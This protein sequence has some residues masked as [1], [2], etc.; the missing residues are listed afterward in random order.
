MNEKQASNLPS[1]I[2]RPT[3]LHVDPWHPAS[4][5]TPRLFFIDILAA[6]WRRRVRAL[7]AGALGASL[8][9]L[10]AQSLPVRYTSTS[11][12][13]I[14]PRERETLK[15][16]QVLSS[17]PA[18]SSVVDT[19]VEVLRS[20]ELARQVMQRLGL[21]AD[22]EFN[23]TLAK[24]SLLKRIAGAFTRIRAANADTGEAGAA[25]PEVAQQVALNSFRQGL[26]VDRSGLTYVIKVSFS[27][28]DAQ[29]SQK[30]ANAVIDTY[31]ADQ[32]HLKDDAVQE[33]NSML[34]ARVESLRKEVVEAERAIA[35]YT[36][37]NGLL[38]AE[39]AN[40][41]ERS[42]TTLS[43]ELSTAKAEQAQHEARLNIALEQARRGGSSAVGEAV[44]SET[45]RALR[46]Q[47]TEVLRK[48]AD[49]ETRYG[50][51]HPA[52]VNI[53]REAADIETAI[54]AE[55]SR[56]IGSLRAN[57]AAARERTGSLQASV[58]DG[59]RDLTKDSVAMVGLAA[60]ERDAE[61]VRAIHKS[62]L[63]RLRQTTEQQGMVGTDARIIARASLPLGSSF[64]PMRLASAAAV[65][66][67]L[68][69]AALA[70]AMAE[71]WDDRIKSAED[72]ERRL[73]LPVL[74]T[75]PDVEHR[76]PA[77]YVVEKPL[78][79]FAEAL[80]DLETS[81]FCVDSSTRPKVVTLLSSVAGEGKTTCTL[82]L[83]R[84]CSMSGARVLLVDTDLRQRALSKELGLDDEPGLI[85]AISCEVSARECL[86]QDILSRAMI[87][88]VGRGPLAKR[89]CLQ[90]DSTRRL[91]EQLRSEFDII[92]VDTA[93]LLAV[94]ESR[95]VA[96]HADAAIVLARWYS[97]PSGA[98]AD[99]IRMARSAEVPVIGLALTRVDERR[100]ASFAYSPHA[101]AR[102]Y[103]YSTYCER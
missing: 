74:T 68:I 8:V 19:E 43:T 81:L 40:L 42:I 62:F 91:F 95:I 2:V 57:V 77:E 83:G 82:A 73:G 22:P 48:K 36:A 103:A 90:S 21:Y 94:A 99:A 79:S 63:T 98:T 41:T 85:E 7:V 24:P 11:S 30:V 49:L 10:F 39:G 12:I 1:P 38:N 4:D 52:I 26:D 45:V 33:A 53:R 44:A 58:A 46:Q 75:I 32:I 17:L 54:N 89:D 71:M 78:S 51:A 37:K 102:R 5:D 86:H 13:M 23:T 66:F 3:T 29:K 76:A 84:L 56:I 14:E 50:E 69:A 25:L 18:E 31:L 93:P 100:Q 60:L 96:H 59:R 65:L 55:I 101:R 97:T 16:D 61:A 67:G 34:A 92:L 6:I 80:R 72:A 28:S 88:P 70:V 47:Q 9:M 20:P 87:L 27:S 15:V 35:E 64:P